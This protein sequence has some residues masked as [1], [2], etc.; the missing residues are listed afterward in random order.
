ME[1]KLLVMDVDGTLT[2]GKI[3]MGP[4]GEVFKAFDIKDGYAINEMLPAHGIV[5]AIITGRT[6]RIVENRARELHITELHQG[7]HDKLDTMKALMKKYDCS[8]D[9]VAYIGDDILD[10]SCMRECG[11]VGCPADACREVKDIAHYV[12]RANGGDGAVREFIEYLIKD[13]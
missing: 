5:P 8:R 12:C 11:V 10:L 9:N 7:H 6:S 1:I 3:N 4:D 13:S 2:D